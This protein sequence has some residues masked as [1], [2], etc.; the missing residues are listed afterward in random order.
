MNYIENYNRLVASRNYDEGIFR[1]RMDYMA[2]GDKTRFYIEGS[3]SFS[4]T[5]KL[6]FKKN[7][8]VVYSIIIENIGTTTI[9][10][11]IE[12]YSNH[13]GAFLKQ[14]MLKRKQVGNSIIVQKLKPYQKEKF[15]FMVKKISEEREAMELIRDL[16]D[17]TVYGPK[18]LSIFERFDEDLKNNRKLFEEGVKHCQLVVNY[19]S[20]EIQQHPEMLFE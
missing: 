2:D 17:D 4:V 20:K 11:P 14:C 9:S 8:A 12:L 15:L 13:N 18:I 1:V 10:E 16:T 7:E 5:K 6:L 19:A 3:K